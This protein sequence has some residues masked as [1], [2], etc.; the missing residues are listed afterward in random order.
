MVR[1]LAAAATIAATVAVGHGVCS[2]YPRLHPSFETKTFRTADIKGAYPASWAK[3]SL[4]P[5]DESLH[6]S[7]V[8]FYNHHGEP[9]TDPP[10]DPL[11]SPSA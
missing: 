6:A 4:F 1:S 9:Q 2:L 7:A 8:F 5:T 11:T 10:E 3:A